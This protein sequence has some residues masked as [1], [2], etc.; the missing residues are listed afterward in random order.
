MSD[1]AVARWARNGARKPIGM[2]FS[3]NGS[4]LSATFFNAIRLVPTTLD[5]AFAR[6]P[7]PC[8]GRIKISKT[9]LHKV[10]PCATRN[11]MGA[12]KIA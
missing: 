4:P 5:W 7:A 6:C 9:E 2:A 11:T 1:A 8:Y 3:A 10:G 12:L